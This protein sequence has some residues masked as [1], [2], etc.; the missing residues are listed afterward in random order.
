MG[1]VNSSPVPSKPTKSKPVKTVTKGPL[2]TQPSSQ[3]HV[4]AIASKATKE[5][6]KSAAKR[7]IPLKTTEKVDDHPAS[8][9]S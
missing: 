7:A 8:E 2:V 3:V 9:K 4:K 6:A 5:S 1:I